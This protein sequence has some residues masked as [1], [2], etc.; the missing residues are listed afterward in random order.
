MISKHILLVKQSFVYAQLNVK[1]ALFQTIRFSIST[2]FKS[3]AVLF[4]PQ[5]R[6]YQVLLH[7]GR[8]YL[9]AIA[10]KGYS[11]FPKAP[12]LLRPHHQI[13]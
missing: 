9:G 12:T 11:T 3:Q 8:M 13:A 7:W 5:V 1:P 10:M 2:Q 4:D 6:R